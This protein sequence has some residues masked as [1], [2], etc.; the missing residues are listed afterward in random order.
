MSSALVVD[1]EVLAVAD[2]VIGTGDF[3]AGATVVSVGF[4]QGIGLNDPGQIAFFAILN[5][6]TQGIFRADPMY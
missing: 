3:L 2:K 1:Q 4:V 5:D 6:G